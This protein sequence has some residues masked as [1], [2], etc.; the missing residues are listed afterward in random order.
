[1]NELYYKFVRLKWVRIVVN[2]IS[3][4]IRGLA[5]LD[6]TLVTVL[7]LDVFNNIIIRI[8]ALFNTS[9]SFI[10]IKTNLYIWLA[11]FVSIEI[12]LRIIRYVLKPEISLLKEEN[13]ALQKKNSELRKRNAQLNSDCKFFQL[14]FQNTISGYLQSF[15]INQLGFS[16]NGNYE[17]RITLFTYDDENENFILQGRYSP[18]DKYRENGKFIYPKKGILYKAFNSSEG[19]YDDKFPQPYTSGNSNICDEYWKYHR[20]KYGL[21]KETVQK[22]TMKSTIMYGYAIKS[23]S[24][25]ETIGI[26]IVESTNQNRFNKEYL[27]KSIEDERKIF[28]NF[29]RHG[30]DLLRKNLKSEGL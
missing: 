30:H 9:W 8:N 11:I 23:H 2:L 19:I 12:G 5:I 22:L 7:Q 26:V 17:D 4:I 27:I 18:N 29:I 15:A 10:E 13:K 28:R 16:K 14:N 6:G 1:M 3:W 20:K 21:T 25:G 24:E